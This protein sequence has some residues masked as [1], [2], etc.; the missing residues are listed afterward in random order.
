MRRRKGAGVV[1]MGED[2]GESLTYQIG[3]EES[4]FNTAAPEIPFA[5]VTSA[6]FGFSLLAMIFL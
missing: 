1:G 4:C 2:A 3:F 5:P 6:T